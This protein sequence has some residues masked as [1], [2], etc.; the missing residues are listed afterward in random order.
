MAFLY[1]VV[2]YSHPPW[3]QMSQFYHRKGEESTIDEQLYF[4]QKHMNKKP[5]QEPARLRS[6]AS[7]Q[8]MPSTAAEVIPPANPAPSPQG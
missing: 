6:T 8:R 3:V 2:N 7:A 4:Y 5:V 1:S